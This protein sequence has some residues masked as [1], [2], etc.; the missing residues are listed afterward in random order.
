MR[1]VP[2][3]GTSELDSTVGADE[4]RAHTGVDDNLRKAEDPSGQ[5]GADNNLRKAEDP[6]LERL[7]AADWSRAVTAEALSP[8]R[9]S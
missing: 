6:P 9:C 8:L 1:G 4:W 5:M 2:A 7:D 3:V